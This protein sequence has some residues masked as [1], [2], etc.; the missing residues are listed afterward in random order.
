MS[1]DS[2]LVALILLVLPVGVGLDLV[3]DTEDRYAKG[4]I[5]TFRFSAL[6]LFILL[7]IRMLFMPFSQKHDLL[8]LIFSFLVLVFSFLIRIL[9]PYK[10]FSAG[11]AAISAGLLV[12]GWL[13]RLGLAK[14]LLA[15][16]LVVAHLVF[17]FAS[18]GVLVLA[19]LAAM[20]YMLQ[21][22]N[23][24]R[25]KSRFSWAVPLEPLDN[26]ISNTVFGG[27]I[28]YTLGLILGLMALVEGVHLV[29]YQRPLN[30]VALSIWAMLG[31]YVWQRFTLRMY[32]LNM[33]R[34]AA[35]AA[36]G[37]LGLGMFMTVWT[38][39]ALL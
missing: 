21:D 26:V 1:V 25:L 13:V 38:G 5:R 30:I 34:L 3:S 8:A 29:L 17:M 37:S 28:L 6:A 23:L 15:N 12:I 10:V 35:L 19:L 33:A 9:S 39:N 27:F 2:F 32:G 24:K 22:Y 4:I 36:F 14:A 20:L 18:C 31:T 11:G 16:P 7:L